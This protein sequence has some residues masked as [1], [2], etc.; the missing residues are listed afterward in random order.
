MDIMLNMWNQNH[1]HRWHA[2][3]YC[4]AFTAFFLKKEHANRIEPLKTEL[5]KSSPFYLWLDK[6][7]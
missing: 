7:E 5:Y 6:E 2:Y 1:E 3:K 4:F